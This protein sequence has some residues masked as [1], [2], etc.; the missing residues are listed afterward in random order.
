MWVIFAS[1]Q[2]FKSL[3]KRYIDKKGSVTKLRSDTAR[4]FTRGEAVDFTK[5]RK[6]ELAQ[7]R[8]FGPQ[9][10]TSVKCRTATEALTAP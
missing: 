10:F 1:P 2:Q 4:F 9:D 8:Y 3:E 5:E 7:I 6:I